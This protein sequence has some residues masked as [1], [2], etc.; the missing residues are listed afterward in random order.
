MPKFNLQS[1]RMGLF[2]FMLL[3]AWAMAVIKNYPP[4]GTLKAEGNWWS[5]APPQSSWFV[6]NVDYNP[7]LLGPA[8]PDS[9]GGNQPLGPPPGSG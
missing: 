8:T 5:Q 3:P 4:G 7:Y 9:C 6:G 2:G 1:F